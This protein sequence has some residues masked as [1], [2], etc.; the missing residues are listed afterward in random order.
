MNKFLKLI[1]L[2]SIIIRLSINKVAKKCLDIK[3]FSKFSWDIFMDVFSSDFTIM[4]VCPF[5]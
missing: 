3:I 2:N 1:Y 4:F 5:L